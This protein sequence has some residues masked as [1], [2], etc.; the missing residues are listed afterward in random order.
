MMFKAW[1]ARRRLRRDETA[2]HDMER[3]RKGYIAREERLDDMR[4]EM[5]ADYCPIVR[6]GCQRDRCRFYYDG[7]MKQRYIFSEVGTHVYYEACPPRCKL[8]KD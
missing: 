3:E 7:E 1:T 8:C 5:A 6:T 4:R 2:A